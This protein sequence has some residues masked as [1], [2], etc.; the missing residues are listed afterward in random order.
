MSIRL[1]PLIALLAFFSSPAAAQPADMTALSENI[2]EI[3]PR[4]PLETEAIYTIV[5]GEIVYARGEED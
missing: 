1:F 3:P 2:L 4:R 5:D